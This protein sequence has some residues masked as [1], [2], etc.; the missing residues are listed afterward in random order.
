MI[1]G[2]ELVEL[3]RQY[4]K[5]SIFHANTVATSLSFLRNG[6][7]LSRKY[8]KEHPA[9]C[10][11]T[12]QYTDETDKLVG[13]DNDIFF[14]VENIWGRNMTCFYGPV[15]FQYDTQVLLG[16]DNLA[17]SRSN[18]KDWMNVPEDQRYFPDVASIRQ[19][20]Y[21]VLFSS[22][23]VYKHIMLQQQGRL[24]FDALEKVILYMPP[25]GVDES[26]L[27]E[28]NLPSA[29]YEELAAECGKR[30]AVLEKRR[31]NSLQWG[32]ITNF[33]MFY[34]PSAAMPNVA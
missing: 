21:L 9:T 13:V 8:V 24:N 6:G 23:S 15:V 28:R 22:W 32:K 10:C 1:D 29:A 3:L 16:R 27:A 4:G 33:E 18:P 25:E 26:S 5:N 19:D 31:M 20:P 12:P 34:S 2:N 11:Q 30:R 17:V 7:L 14:D